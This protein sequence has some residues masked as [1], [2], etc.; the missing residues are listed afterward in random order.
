V[1]ELPV[2]KHPRLKGYD[3]NQNGSY[4]ITFC[5]KDKH[6]ILG[7]LSVGRGI[8]DAP[9][10]I[11]SEYGNALREAIEFLN[12]NENG[13]DIVHYVIMP[14]H[15]HMIVRVEKLYGGASRMPRPTNAL[16]PK[17]VSSIKRFTNKKVGFNLWQRSFHDHIIRSADEYLRIWQYIDENPMRWFEDI[18]YIPK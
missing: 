12:N 6:E 17:L 3:Y 14:N 8:L 10:V 5:V 18:Y 15:V 11:L 13:I 9:L 2:R 4:F 16:I 1:K 7:Q